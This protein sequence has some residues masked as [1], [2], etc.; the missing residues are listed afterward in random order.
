VWASLRTAIRVLNRLD[1]LFCTN[2]Q[3]IVSLSHSKTVLRYPDE[4][5]DL[6]SLTPETNSKPGGVN[7]SYFAKRM[8]GELPD[9]YLE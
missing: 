8:R 1:V 7:E 4:L 5:P 6:S 2:W 9:Y 3:F